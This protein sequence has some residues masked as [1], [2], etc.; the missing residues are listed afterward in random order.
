MALWVKICGL[1]D[2]AAVAAAMDAGADAIGFVFAESVRRIEPAEAAI[3]ARAVRGNC[4]IVAVM[5][6]PGQTLVDEVCA[7]LRPDTVQTDASDFAGLSLP[8]GTARLPVYRDGTS[9]DGAITGK[10]RHRLLYE[11]VR[12]GSGERADWGRARELAGR[13]ELILAGGLGG[14]NVG[15]AIAAVRPAGVDVSSGVESAPGKKDTHKIHAFVA[16]ARAA[17]TT[18]PGAA[19]S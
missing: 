9:L 4:E 18:G 15:S 14:A 6:H 11:G 5:Q 1:T 3:L 12:S 13:F 7:V 16:A 17:A 2:A 10:H 19:P 8:S